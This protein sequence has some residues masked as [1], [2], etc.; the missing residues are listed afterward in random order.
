MSL[1]SNFSILII[2]VFDSKRRPILDG[3]KPA[4]E[5]VVLPVVD[6]AVVALLLPVGAEE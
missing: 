5:G 3:I 4:G 6:L 1:A 2:S